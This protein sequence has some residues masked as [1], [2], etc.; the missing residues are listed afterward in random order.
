M[1]SDICAGLWS[2][3]ATA[4]MKQLLF[5]YVHTHAHARPQRIYSGVRDVGVVIMNIICLGWEKKMDCV[6][7]VNTH[8]HTPPVA[9][10]GTGQGITAELVISPGLTGKIP[11]AREPQ[12]R[13]RCFNPLPTTVE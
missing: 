6:S 7:C 8:R 4:H 13:K 5:R 9:E 1:A 2:A 3:A 10:A 11:P 12:T